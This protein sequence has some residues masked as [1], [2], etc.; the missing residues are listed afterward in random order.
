MGGSAIGM[1]GSAMTMFIWIAGSGIALYA[2]HRLGLWMEERGWIYYQKRH[3][4]GGALGSAALN[5]QA[6]LEPGARHV[7]EMKQE[8]KAEG[9]ESGDPPSL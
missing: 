4:T 2:V 3:A 8:E 7:L 9:A 6:I 1:G 5:L